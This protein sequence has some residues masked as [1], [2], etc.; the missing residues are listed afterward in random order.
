[1]GLSV[2]HFRAALLLKCTAHYL[3]MGVE[4]PILHCLMLCDK[5]VRKH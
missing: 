5:V 1:M 3:T 4:D 2:A